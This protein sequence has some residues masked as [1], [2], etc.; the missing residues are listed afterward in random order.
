MATGGYIQASIEVWMNAGILCQ[1]SD[2]D[3]TVA[4]Y[5]REVRILILLTW[6]QLI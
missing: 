4:L 3:R 6:I 1:M 5:W 2:S